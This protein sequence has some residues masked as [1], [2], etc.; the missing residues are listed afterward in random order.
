MYLFLCIIILIIYIIL[1]VIL[2]PFIILMSFYKKPT[3]KNIDL[4]DKKSY[5]INIMNN[6]FEKYPNLSTNMYKFK[7]NNMDY[8][9]DQ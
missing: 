8:N 5:L 3:Y 7:Y 1:F 4:S 2:Y 9:M 6:I